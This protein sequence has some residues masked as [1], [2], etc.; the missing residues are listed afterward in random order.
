VIKVYMC[1]E[2]YVCHMYIANIKFIADGLQLPL[3]LYN[4][5]NTAALSDT[6]NQCYNKT[7][8]CA[9]CGLKLFLVVSF[10]FHWLLIGADVG[11]ANYIV[12]IINEYFT[13]YFPRAIAVANSLHDGGY[14]ETFIYTTHPWLVSLYLDCPPNLVLVGIRLQV[15]LLE[16]WNST[17][18]RIEFLQCFYSVRWV[19][20]RASC[21]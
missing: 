1:P 7:A 15:S 16:Y 6:K 5:D 9:Q 21:T 13:Q 17:E 2:P 12:N 10:A 14:V 8:V 4:V 19:A 18:I 11:Y 3:I 20:L